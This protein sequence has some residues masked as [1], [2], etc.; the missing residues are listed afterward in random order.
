MA[1]RKEDRLFEAYAQIRHKCKC[2]HTLYIPA[3]KEFVL[4]NY[5]GRKVYRDEKVKF[6]NLLIA[7]FK[8]A[9]KNTD[10]PAEISF[11]C[12]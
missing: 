7:E 10:I 2:S 12:E 4:C 1:W 6:K 9:G 5:C 11:G 3:Y 8:K